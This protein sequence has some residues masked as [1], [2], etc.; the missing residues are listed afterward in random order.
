MMRPRRFDADVR[1]EQNGLDVFEQGVVDG[2]PRPDDLGDPVGNRATS[3]AQRSTETPEQPTPYRGFGARIPSEKADQWSGVL[4]E[5]I[6]NDG[7]AIRPGQTTPAG[8]P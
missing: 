3:L 8:V 1:G 5:T 6:Q 2:R 7:T 4:G